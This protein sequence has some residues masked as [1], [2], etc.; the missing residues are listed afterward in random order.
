MSKNRK[1]K[2]SYCL[3]YLLRKMLHLLPYIYNVIL[4]EEKKSDFLPYAPFS[5]MSMSLQSSSENKNHCIAKLLIHM[6][7]SVLLKCDSQTNELSQF[8]CALIEQWSR[9]R[10]AISIGVE[11]IVFLKPYFIQLFERVQC[12]SS[13]TISWAMTLASQTK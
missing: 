13:H 9:Y 7:Q 2:I 4:L 11:C 3:A 5:S 8:S 1:Q 10:T 12:I 6:L